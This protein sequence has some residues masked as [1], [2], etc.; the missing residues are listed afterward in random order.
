MWKRG[1][2]SA[3]C[4][5]AATAGGPRARRQKCPLPPTSPARP[6][7]LEQKNGTR[8][9]F[10]L[11]GVHLVVIISLSLLSPKVHHC[12]LAQFPLPIAAARTAIGTLTKSALQ[13]V[14]AERKKD[15]YGLVLPRSGVFSAL[16]SAP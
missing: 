3:Q 9:S 2:W 11:A 8:P 15:L 7:G 16:Y 5:S 10:L 13:R 6:V 14:T 1:A 12:E 4:R